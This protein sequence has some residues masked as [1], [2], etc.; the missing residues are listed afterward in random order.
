MIEPEGSVTILVADDNAYNLQIIESVLSDY[1]YEIK[2]ATNGQEALESVLKEPPELILIDIHMPV[3]DGYETCHR[4][5]ENNSTREIPI[6][7]VSAMD[8][9]SWCC[10]HNSKCS[11]Q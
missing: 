4:L 8:E 6:I 7:F 11:W 10:S 9:E 2:L 3:M 5:K 1:G